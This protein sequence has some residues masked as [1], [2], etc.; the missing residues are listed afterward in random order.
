MNNYAD[1][2]IEQMYARDV[3]TSG[4]VISAHGGA[5]MFGILSRKQ[6]SRC[7]EWKA[8]RDFRKDNSKKSGYGSYCKTC[9]NKYNHK[10][11]DADP[12]KWRAIS[13]VW[14][15]AHPEQRRVRVRRWNANHPE[16]DFE[17]WHERRALK[18]ANGGK[19]TG[20]EWQALK[21]FYNF[22]CLKCG[23]KEPEIKLT[24]DHVLPLKLGGVNSI[25]NIQPLCGSCN[26]SKKDSHI[27]YRGG[28]YG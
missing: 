16:R 4:R 11:Y 24:A 23:R 27:D 2:I 25:D 8:L 21:E 1:G 7:G 28:Q 26:S 6:C 17:H 10:R 5:S 22:T 13:R 19:F 3:G 18:L 9:N 20:K 12:E 15:A 14:G